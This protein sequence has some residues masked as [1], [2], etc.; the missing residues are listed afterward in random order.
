METTPVTFS[1]YRTVFLRDESLVVA[2]PRLFRDFACR[3]GL[4]SKVAMVFMIATMVFV[5]IFPSF[6]SAMTGYSSN[7]K[8][9][10][11]NTTSSSPSGLDGSNYMAFSS[12]QRVLYVI[13]DG[14][15]VALEGDYMVPYD[16]PYTNG[17]SKLKHSPR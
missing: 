9:Y 17:F 1:T 7:V 12:F 2:I 4:H 11:R 6:A 13:H 10:I 5:L 3:R 8:S 16:T 14:W 15:R